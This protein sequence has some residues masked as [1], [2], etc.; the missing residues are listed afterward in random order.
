[1]PAILKSGRALILQ[2]SEYKSRLSPLSLRLFLMQYHPRKGDALMFMS[3]HPNGTFDKHALHG[4]CPVEK[5]EK[6]VMTR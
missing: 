4:G 1:M 3:V 2:L 5:G 6:M